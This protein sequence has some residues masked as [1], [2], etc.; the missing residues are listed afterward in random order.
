M[1]ST[2]NGKIMKSIYVSKTILSQAID[3]SLFKY[4]NFKRL[5]EV[6]TGYTT[7]EPVQMAVTEAIE[8]AVSSLVLE[9]IKDK[10]WEADISKEE[11]VSLLAKFEGEKEDADV[12]AI[13]GRD[14]I[15][16]RSRFAIEFT[17]GASLMDGDYANPLLRPM[18]RGALKYFF[19]PGFN[20]SASLNAFKLANKDRLDV[21]YVT[22]DV[23]GELLLL[24]KDKLSPYIYGGVGYGDNKNFD[25]FHFKFQY[26]A[27][28]EYMASKTLGIKLY[29]EQN[30]NF[31]DTIDY[32]VRGVRDDYYYRFGL[33]LTFYFSDKKT[34]VFH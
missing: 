4:V 15:K 16:R 29:A 28:L 26:G 17:G 7:N 22:F 3:Q 20:L 24:P 13:Y 32:M 18:S 1:V 5:L 27:G 12:K 6:E 34:I 8:K 19:S 10:I 25:N 30:I 11:E 9:G 2:S 21:G 33:G 14:L 23:N 31:S